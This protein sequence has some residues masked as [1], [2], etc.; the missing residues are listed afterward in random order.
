MQFE[1]NNWLEA[2]SSIYCLLYRVNTVTFWH[3]ALPR[4]TSGVSKLW[5]ARA[6]LVVRNLVNK[7]KHHFCDSLRCDKSV[8]IVFSIYIW[9]TT[10]VLLFH[11]FIRRHKT[12]R[13]CET[14][15]TN[16]TNATAFCTCVGSKCAVVN[17]LLL[18]RSWLTSSKLSN[19]YKRALKI[20]P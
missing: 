19:N 10:L 9:N 5:Y 15:Q 14:K 4:S 11:V 7:I 8:S 13:N 3:F 12:F 16:F 20:F 17:V 18:K 6:F 2:L 1:D